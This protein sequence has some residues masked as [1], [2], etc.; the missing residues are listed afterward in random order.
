MVTKVRCPACKT[1][2]HTGKSLSPGK[3]IKCPKCGESFRYGGNGTKSK[4]PSALKKQ[5]GPPAEQPTPESPQP[6][7]EIP[8]EETLPGIRK[9]PALL[10]ASLAVFALGLVGGGIL[11]AIQLMKPASAVVATNTLPGSK[12]NDVEED[13]PNIESKS[14]AKQAP[15]D[16]SEAKLPKNDEGSNESN[17]DKTGP[18]TPPSE[19]KTAPPQQPPKK[20]DSVPNDIN[21]GPNAGSVT[22]AEQLG[23]ETLKLG[24]DKM[25][26]KYQG[27]IMRIY[28]RVSRISG[29]LVFFD[30]GLKHS[31]GLPVKIAMRF[32]NEAQVRVLNPYDIVIIEGEFYLVSV[33]GPSFRNCR[34][35]SQK[36]GT[37][38]ND[39][40]AKR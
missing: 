18:K 34:L 24:T 22:A 11:L 20:N 31:K 28:G 40:G 37:A 9:I 33:F 32:A 1:N 35:A 21:S 25:T 36:T 13:V 4:T 2:L 3:A 5:S 15:A 19:L 29:D 6:A 8:P 27:K 39:N 38:A 7:A 12:N 14:A 10:L 16:N 26:S 30:T 17:D 23:K